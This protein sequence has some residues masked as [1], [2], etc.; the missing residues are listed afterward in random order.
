M[1]GGK[2]E[3]PAGGDQQQRALHPARPVA[4]E[5]DAEGELEK[6]EA[7]E[8][9]RGQQAQT[10]RSESELQGDRRADDRV[11]GTVEIGEEVA[12]PEGKADHRKESDRA[13]VTCRRA[14]VHPRQ[15]MW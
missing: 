6:T 15:S 12:G 7:Q 1:G 11:D 4:I 14:I 9:D 3:R 8:V 10:C 2:D 13:T 5:Q